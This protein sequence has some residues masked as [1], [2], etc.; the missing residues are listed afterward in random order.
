MAGRMTEDEALRAVEREIAERGGSVDLRAEGT[1]RLTWHSLL[2][3]LVVR[4]VETRGEVEREE[5]GGKDLSDRTFY[6]D[7]YDHPVP[8][9][10]D[11]RRSQRLELV[12]EGSVR[13]EECACD[14]GRE[15]C[16]RCDGRERIPCEESVACPDCRHTLCCL[17]CEGTGRRRRARIPEDREADGDRPVKRIACARCRAPEAACPHCRGGG[18]TTCALCGGKGSV[19]C[20]K[21]GGEGTAEHGDCGGAGVRTF[22]TEG[23]VERRPHKDPVRLPE[24]RPPLPVRRR[25]A[26]RGDWLD[27]VL[28]PGDRLPGGLDPVHRAAVEPRLAVRKGEVARRV[29]IRSLPLARIAVDSVPDRVFYAFPGRSG[30]E[31]VAVP[32]RR[33]MTGI[34][35]AA[36]CATT[37][38]AVLLVLL[39]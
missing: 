9:P 12:R 7:L 22:W 39:R 8:P 13:E 3:C 25:A 16:R 5:K 20:P 15:P 35:A 31:A 37:L 23:V 30:T 34:A 19:P 17:A 11:P 29:E 18:R 28:G 38:C 4:S 6:E 1:Y 10:A 26:G 32:S 36:V 27:A 33:R 14:G 2:H 21:C 24:K